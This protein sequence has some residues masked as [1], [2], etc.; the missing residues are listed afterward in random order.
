VASPDRRLNWAVDGADWPLRETSTFV[1][2]AGLRWHVQRA[3]AGP[4]AL[5]IHGTGA[6]THSWRGLAPLLARRFDVVACDLPGHGFTDMPRASEM[7]LPGM[8]RAIGALLDR[9]EVR[10][11]L[12]VGHSAGA[13]ILARMQLDG[14]IALK[15]LVSLAGALLPLEGWAGR[16]FSPAARLFAA[17]PL[18]PR[19]F[20][21]YALEPGAV[22]RLIEGTGSRLDRTGIDLYGRL[23][24]NPC[25]AAAALAMMA[26]WDLRA[27]ARDLPLL[28]PPPVLIV[29]ANDRTIPPGDAARVRQRVP[30]ATVI[31][32]P[33][34]GHLAHEESPE[35]V[36]AIVSD[37]WTRRAVVST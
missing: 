36:D 3:G 15:L 13:A 31:M 16:V 25:H 4:P 33:S 19:L 6:A 7:S 18:V 22:E 37:R 28:E 29:G 27:L 8:A 20:S 17:T 5:L 9:L 34:C 14:R 30:G 2:A 10:P 1:E 12:G 24:R 11:A 26:N 21:R 32:L 23:V 35:R